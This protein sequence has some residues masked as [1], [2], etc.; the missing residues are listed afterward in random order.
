MLAVSFVLLLV[1]FTGWCD[2]LSQRKRVSV[3]E[4]E[5][6]RAKADAAE[7]VE[8]ADK[9]AKQA[10]E[11]A[12]ELKELEERRNEKREDL[13]NAQR[14]SDAAGSDYDR[15]RRESRTDQPDADALCRE[16]AELGYPCK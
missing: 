13:A 4:R 7:H 5:A 12:G 8:R 1:L 15:V 14:D 10:A 9:L 3:H 6:A 2:S 11:I 16:L